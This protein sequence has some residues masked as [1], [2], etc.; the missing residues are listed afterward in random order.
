METLYGTVILKDNLEV[1]PETVF[2]VK[3]FFLVVYGGVW[4]PNFRQ[5]CQSVNDIRQALN[6]EDPSVKRTVEAFYLSCDKD[7]Q[8]FTKCYK[9]LLDGYTWC[10]I[11]WNDLRIQQIKE[12]Y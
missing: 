6:S 5:V 10:T 4:A 8:E 7:P 9:E 2:K 12:H 1:E 3:E 11:P